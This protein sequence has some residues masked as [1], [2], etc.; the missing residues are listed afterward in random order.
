MTFED[1]YNLHVGKTA[2]ILG[3]GPSLDNWLS[4][5]AILPPNN[6]TISVNTTT[7]VYNCDYC[8]TR[9]NWGHDF[10]APGKWFMPLVDGWELNNAPYKTVN[11]KQT[12]G[13]ALWYIPYYHNCSRPMPTREFI[14]D[15]RLLPTPSGSCIN[16][17]LIAYYMG[18]DNIL[19]I[20][21]DGGSLYSDAAN[22]ISKIGVNANYD[23]L[24]NT[25]DC[26]ANILFKDKYRHWTPDLT[27]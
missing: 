18:V 12:P 17:I 26:Y 22:A 1:H 8:V 21:I 27:F 16:A 14:R 13:G 3:K 2:V 6:I 25:S 24:K 7:L 11:W 10:K 4:G 19:F 9:H 5:G 23:D 15:Y 20:G